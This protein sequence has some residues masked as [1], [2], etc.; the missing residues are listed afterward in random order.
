MDKDQIALQLILK[1]MDQ[2]PKLEESSN[3]GSVRED[4][5]RLQESFVDPIK[6]VEMFKKIRRALE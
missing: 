3:F 4:Q 1:I 5:H 6:V 2:T